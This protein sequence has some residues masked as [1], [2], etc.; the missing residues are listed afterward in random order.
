MQIK[1]YITSVILFFLISA[2]LSAQEKGT[3]RGIVK[4]SLNSES[5]PFANVIIREL[6]TGASTN[7][8]GYFIIPSLPVSDKYNVVVSYIGYKTKS[9]DVKVDA[10]KI[11]ELEIFLTPSTVEIGVVE[12]IEYLTPEENIPDLGKTILTVKRLEVIPKGVETDLLRALAGVPGVKSSGDVSAK[13][14]VRGGEPNQNL[15]LVDGVPLYYPY[16]AIGLFSVIDY[17]LI[18][19][20]EF[21]RGGFPSYIGRAISSVMKVNTKDGN[22]NNFSG[23]GSISLLSVKGL[24]EGPIPNGSFYFTGRKSVSNKILNRFLSNELPVDFYDAAFKINYSSPDFFSGAKFTVHGLFSSDN[25]KYDDPTSPD[26]NWKNSLIGFKVF[27]VGSIPFFLDFG[28]NFSSFSNEIF[29]KKSDI[30]P[31]RNEL[32]DFTISTDFL[33]VLDNKDE[34]GIGADVKYIQSKMFLL[35]RFNFRADA[36]SEGLSSNAYANYKFLRFENLG[37]DLGIRLNLKSLDAGGDF[38]EPRINLTYLITKNISI[39]GAYGIYQ[40]E[41]TTI[42]DEREVLSLF[43]PVVIIPEYLSKAKAAHYVFGFS[44]RL[45]NSMIL[46]IEGY[47]RKIFNSPTLNENKTLF[48]EPDL[49]NSTGESYGGELSINYSGAP[50]DFTIAY[51]LSWAFKEVNGLKYKP[52]YDSRHNINLTASYALPYGWQISTSWNYHS[53]NP[54]TQIAG[55]YDQYSLNNI[56]SNYNIYGTL[57]PI[58]LF[59]DKNSAMLPDYHRLDI[60]IAKK[61]DLNFMKLN[62]DISAI[63]VY[64]RKNIFYFE[65]KNGKRINMLPFLLTFTLKIEL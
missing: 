47:Y 14:S 15:V 32:N 24:V 61:I 20:L 26:Y 13:F 11:T 44:S 25:L 49:I 57:S 35:N 59:S 62:L 51:T 41:L 56:F 39:K 42:Y 43:D 30:K 28:V 65:S 3:I 40:Q 21:Y 63:N 18:N 12:K 8:R 58:L 2:P 46:D 54:F 9:V 31:K 36:G 22:K 38:F 34:F 6:S 52:R 33:Y 45:S 29:Q 17:D 27:T 50:L 7:N 4:D 48:S 10:Q 53:G 60:M 55:F 5:L 64:D 16:H 19:N 23:K 1:K 37:A